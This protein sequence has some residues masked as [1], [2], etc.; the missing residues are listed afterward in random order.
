MNRLF[1]C[2]SC[3][4][5]SVVGEASCVP[6]ETV[7]ADSVSSST[8]PL[9]TDSGSGGVSSLTRS[10]LVRFLSRDDLFCSED[11]R[12]LVLEDEA[13]L[14]ADIVCLF[15]N[16][17]RLL[18]GEMRF[19]SGDIVLRIFVR[20]E[21]EGV[22]SGG[23]EPVRRLLRSLDPMVSL[24]SGASSGTSVDN[25]PKGFESVPNSKNTRM[26]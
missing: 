14:L 3:V 4:M 18:A 6:A 25:S 12:L 2:R 5:A 10:L 9:N 26:W 24:L 1:C 17:V 8:V 23:S 16:D 7:A 11:A 21:L 13:R 22:S 19:L 15:P 20:L